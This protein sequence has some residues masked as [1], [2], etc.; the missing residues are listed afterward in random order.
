MSSTTSKLSQLELTAAQAR[1]DAAMEAARTAFAKKKAE[2]K[3]EALKAQLELERLQREES[4]AAA[5]ARASVLDDEIKSH[6]GT[7]LRSLP[8]EEPTKRVSE[9]VMALPNSNNIIPTPM[10]ALDVTPECSVADCGGINPSPMEYVKKQI[11]PSS[12]ETCIGLSEIVKNMKKPK[13]EVKRFSGNPIDFPKFIRQFKS[14]IVSNTDTSEER[15]TY[16]EANKVVCG[17]S[18]LPSEKAYQAAMDQLS[19]RY[20]D[21][22]VIASTYIKKALEWPTIR[23]GE[24]K[25]LDE[26]AFPSRMHECCRACKCKQ[27]FG[28]SRTLEEVNVQTTSLPT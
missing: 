14:R 12:N 15:M 3:I 24:P 17:F 1:A 16:L 10:P 28:V 20:G 5:E 6:S 19:D 25:A 8:A 23:P 18:H 4:L 11:N 21:N 22:E 2:A 13:H 26:Y 9:Y 7:E 27:N